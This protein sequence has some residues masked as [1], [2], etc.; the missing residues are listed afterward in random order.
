ME[1]SLRRFYMCLS[2][3][4]PKPDSHLLQRLLK[5][6]LHFFFLLLLF[7]TPSFSQKNTAADSLQQL[8]R[9]ATDTTRARLLNNLAFTYLNQSPDK[10]LATS[11]EALALAKKLNDTINQARAL[12]NIGVS[13]EVKSDFKTA[14]SY[15]KQC[16]ALIQPERNPKLGTALYM[17]FANVYVS[18]G[19]NE[20]SIDYYIKALKLNEQLN[21]KQV[22]VQI[23]IN[24]ANV[25]FNLGKYELANENYKKLLASKGIENEKALLGNVYNG[26]GMICHAQKKY[27]EAIPDFLKAID[28]YKSVNAKIYIPAP[29]VNLGLSYSEEKKYELAIKYFNEARAAC[30]EIGSEEGVIFVD[31]GLGITYN[32]MGSYDQ[33]IPLFLKAIAAS[34]KINLQSTLQDGYKQLSISYE[35]K[36]NYAQSY[37]YLQ[38]YNALT[39]SLYSEKN[40]KQLLE[41]KQYENEKR[42]HDLELL[43]E[44]EKTQNIALRQKQ[45]VVYGVV[46]GLVLTSLLALFAFRSYNQ[47]RKA[48]QILQVKNE[49]IAKQKN[50]IE[51]QKDLLS[52]KNVQITDSINYAK[53]LQDSI[54]SQH[55]TLKAFFSDSFIFYKPKDIVSGDFFWLHETKSHIYLAAVDCTGHGVPGA[56]MSIV[57]HG[58]LTQLVTETFITDPAELLNALNVKIH[59]SL[60][61][62]LNSSV[63]DGMDL[64]LCIIDRKDGTLN[65]AGAKNPLYLVKKSSATSEAHLEEFKADKI[66]IGQ[67]DEKK[68]STKRVDLRPGDWIYLFSDGFA[69]QKGGTEY[70][71]FYYDSFRALLLKASVEPAAQQQIL[72]D[73]TLNAWIGNHE[74]MDDILVVGVK[75]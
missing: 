63:R 48:N 73:D 24:M 66:S 18:S 68:F 17:N 10:M 39:D 14:L 21:D 40:N 31:V 6:R 70:R 9:S 5:I 27:E 58:I 75:I 19:E 51:G 38:K 16:L 57:A 43:Q 50:E 22:E 44:K 74:Q 20:K 69:D 25:Y 13:Y 72:L 23:L 26:M 47:K 52:K 12:A 60:K 67:P 28:C 33:A 64:A 1:R 65:Y 53:R 35:K 34:K 2:S 54:L 4:F 29:M 32:N 45:L 11:F 15:Y 62:D 41:L 30:I 61:Q 7:T 56:F 42:D 8:L 71:K 37:I 3:L 46:G 55:E 59:T 49:E 36:K